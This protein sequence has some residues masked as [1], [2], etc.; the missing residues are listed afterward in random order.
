MSTNRQRPEPTPRV[1]RTLLGAGCLVAAA[2]TVVPAVAQ[3]WRWPWET[4]T[5]R[6]QRRE[7]PVQP[8]QQQRV[9]QA[10]NFGGG[11]RANVCLQ[12]ERR[13]ANVANRGRTGS[14]RRGALR[15]QLSR[16]RRDSRLLEGRLESN[17]CWD[18]FFFQRTLRNTR[19]CVSTYRR[20]QRA[21]QAAK[22]A[23]AELQQYSGSN[24]QQMQDDIVRELAR[25]RCGR[26]YEQQARRMN[27]NPF[28][29]FFEDGD[30]S[31]LAGRSNTYR[32][33]PFATY[34]TLCVRLCDGYY[35]PVSFSTLPNY[36]ERDAQACQSQCA[37][38]TGLY[39]HQNP[40]SSIDQ[41]VS[42][43]DNSTYTQLNTA[44]LYRKQYVKGC[45]CKTAE[46]IPD[47]VQANQQTET[48]QRR[49]F[50]PVR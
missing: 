11:S 8:R 45:S 32:G 30:S 36:F 10:E 16:A 7:R 3:D 25:N 33:L 49:R 17:D 35:F 21:R 14:D 9:P 50:S 20:L 48:T 12:L 27:S 15:N 6:E 18:E 40:G 38:P 28:A 1:T 13:L 34:R 41:M 22:D 5:R 44:F 4:E 39:Y 31:G 26:A 47:G 23:S 43:Q 37:A 29:S 46:Y 24:R 2:F 42:A 19:A